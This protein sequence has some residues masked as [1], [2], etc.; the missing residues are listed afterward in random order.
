M[1]A[2]DF[3]V[4]QGQK[5]GHG[6]HNLNYLCKVAKI[7][8]LICFGVTLSFS[9]ELRAAEECEKLEPKTDS[10]CNDP[11]DTTTGDESGQMS[12][13]AEEFKAA[14]RSTGSIGNNQANQC[15][16]QQRVQ[17]LSRQLSQLKGQACQNMITKCA[18]TCE[19]EAQDYD[20][21]AQ[22]VQATNPGL[23]QQYRDK[24]RKKREIR[25]R[26]EENETNV[27]RALEQA[28]QNAERANT[29]A[30]CNQQSAQQQPQ[31][32][33]QNDQQRPSPTP[34]PTP[35]PPLNCN[36]PLSAS[37]PLCAHRGKPDDSAQLGF[38]KGGSGVE[39]GGSGLSG[40]SEYRD[41]SSSLIEGGSAATSG[42]GYAAG[43][44]DGGSMGF[45]GW[46]SSG[47]SMDTDKPET[48]SGAQTSKNSLVADGGG[49]GGGRGGGGPGPVPPD[50]Q[51]VER[52]NQKKLGGMTVKAV[53]GITGPMG[54]SLFEKVSQQYRR[55]MSNLL[56]E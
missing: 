37:N 25:S 50:P 47:S 44:G 40:S 26:C 38:F 4:G 39:V 46:G 31:Q 3:L 52:I 12:R 17:D 42:S 9:T 48:A 41:P 45:G 18:E 51:L 14:G 49:G 55:Q 32:P 35:T 27:A 15:E 19:K 33:Q 56:P 13:L 43:G 28:A 24:A 8:A 5:M 2:R 7:I 6:R 53:D 34:A 54:A 16:N 23:A 11:N 22:Q 20:A 30:Q 21:K 1:N 36:D 10:A 29:N